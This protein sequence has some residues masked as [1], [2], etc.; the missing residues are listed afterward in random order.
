MSYKVA[1]VGATGN[2]GREMLQILDERKFPVSEVV[3]LASAP[4]AGAHAGRRGSQ[5]GGSGGSPRGPQ[6][7]R[8][9]NPGGPHARGDARLLGGAR[10]ADREVDLEEDEFSRRRRPGRLQAGESRVARGAGSGRRSGRALDEDRRLSPRG[11]MRRVTRRA[12]LRGFVS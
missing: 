9:R 12:P 5:E 11:A 1:V 7:C 3:A 2:V 4:P 10:S 6:G 8:H